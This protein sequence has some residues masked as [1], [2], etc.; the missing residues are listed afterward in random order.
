MAPLFSCPASVKRV[1][2]SFSAHIAFMTQDHWTSYWREGP[3]SSFGEQTPEWYESRLLPFWVRTFEAQEM[4]STI[5]DL[6][7]GNGAVTRIAADVNRR[8]DK[9]FRLLAVDRV[10]TTAPEGVE[11]LPNMPLEELDTGLEADLVTSQFG[12]E[13]SRLELSLPRLP[14]ILKPSGRLVMVAHHRDSVLSDNSRLELREYRAVL[15]D[16]P[17]F[18][19]MEKLLRVMG[20]PKTA[21][22]RQRLQRNKAAQSA[23]LA[24][25]RSISKL[26]GRFHDGLVIAH[27]LQQLSPLFQQGMPRPVDEKLHYLAQVRRDLKR[28]RQ[29]LND[30]IAA[31]LDD[32]AVEKLKNLAAQQSLNSTRT[33]RLET[34]DGHL[35]AWVLAFS[36]PDS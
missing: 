35:L 34:D 31:A 14:S 6:A 12:L 8:Q 7:T 20:S 27:L 13:Y 5:L 30:Q 9:K 24:V 11:L 33:E 25:N 15:S 28:A 29:R 2:F 1:D 16:E 17:L 18:E 19:R 3:V 32:T 10:P 36:K 21:A 4:G 22:E 26:T 23:R